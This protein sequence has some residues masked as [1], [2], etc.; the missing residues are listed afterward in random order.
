MSSGAVAERYAR[1]IFELAEEASQV[2]QVADQLGKLADIYSGSRELRVVLENPLVTAEQRAA[3]LKD[4]GARVGLGPLATNSVR[5]I[6]A[7]R[8]L[9]ALPEIAAHIRQLADQKAGVIRAQ[10]TSA[11]PLSEEFVVRLKAQLERSTGKRV[12]LERSTDPSLI[13][14]IVT[15]IGDHTVDGSVRGRLSD[16]ERQLL[17]GT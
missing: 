2:P 17:P 5:L 16:L 6:A 14:G 8:R 15:R 4:L 7:R 9:L 12:Q 3:I 11:A 10:V 1:A 13:A